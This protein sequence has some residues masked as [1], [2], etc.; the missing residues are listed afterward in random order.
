ML[1]RI[2]DV[3][4]ARYRNAERSVTMKLSR[5]F[6]RHCHASRDRLSSFLQQSEHSTATCTAISAEVQ[7]SFAVKEIQNIC[8]T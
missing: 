1:L 4:L 6:Q 8:S 3:E 2:V 7:E 5:I